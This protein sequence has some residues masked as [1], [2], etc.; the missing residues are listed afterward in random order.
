MIVRFLS[1]CVSVVC[2]H[3]TLVLTTRIKRFSFTVV[4][5]AVI[6]QQYFKVALHSYRFLPQLIFPSTLSYADAVV[7]VRAIPN[8]VV[9]LYIHL[10]YSGNEYAVCALLL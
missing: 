4:T 8:A 9:L 10:L 6:H 5:N 7:F 2:T 1:V 3:S